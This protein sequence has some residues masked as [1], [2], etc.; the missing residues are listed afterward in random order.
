MYE[1]Y[2]K[3]GQPGEKYDLSFEE[4]AEGRYIVGDPSTCIQEL[5]DYVKELRRAHI[6][7][8][9]TWR[10]MKHNSTISCIRLV[11][12]KTILEVVANG[13]VAQRRNYPPHRI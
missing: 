7:F 8:R 3:W 12:K 13:E 4:L 9:M 11:G 10:G 2:M 5:H 6:S 1:T